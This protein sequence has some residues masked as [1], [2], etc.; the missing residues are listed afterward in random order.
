DVLGRGGPGWVAGLAPGQV[1]LERVRQLVRDHCHDY[2]VLPCDEGLL[3]TVLGHAEGMARLEDHGRTLPAPV[4]SV[5]GI[6]GESPV[7]QALYR[8]LKRAA[9]TDAPVCIGGA[10]GT[11]KELAA[12]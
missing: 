10:T 1:R 8:Q 5:D 2:V 12:A 9:L 7:M 6:V 3:A 11:G 4:A